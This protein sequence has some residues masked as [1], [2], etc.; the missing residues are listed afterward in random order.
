MKG[1]LPGGAAWAA[2]LL[3]A[4]ALCAALAVLAVGAP[5]AYAEEP[6]DDGNAVNPH[7]MPDSSFIYDTSIADL[8][9][10]DS[11]YDDQTVQV[12][13]EAIGDSIKADLEGRRRW[14]TLSSEGDSATIAVFMSS[15][16]ATKIDTFGSYDAR[17]TVLQVQGTFHLVCP[18][19]DGVSD[20]HAEVVTVVDQGVR[21]A[22]RFNFNA[23]IPG[24]VAV[25][26]GL[27][28]TGVFYWLR[29]RQR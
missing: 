14:I 10:A 5:A 16:S 17:G 23:F 8:S 25:V 2:R 19:H 24:I 22:D 9:T 21:T 12:T 1:V 28:M 11:Y 29:E 20:L 18:E 13:G 7:Q 4:V 26:A 3:A 6:S 27:V 15:D